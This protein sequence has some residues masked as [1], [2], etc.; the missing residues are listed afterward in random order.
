MIDPAQLREVFDRAV[1]VP[2]AD[3]ASFL[4]RAC[5]RDVALRQEVE[6]LLGADSRLGEIFDTAFP[7]AEGSAPP[8]LARTMRLAPGMRLGPYSVVEAIG[9][10]GMGEVYKAHDTRLNR[11]V[12]L[13]VLPRSLTDDAA[14]KQRFEREA[15]AVAALSHPHICPLFDVGHQNGLDF[16]VMEYLDGETL[17]AR[18]ARGKL[19]FDEA[20]TFALHIADALVAAHA[21]GIVH[22]DLKPGNVMLTAGG[23]KLLDFGLANERQPLFVADDRPRRQ[24]PITQPGTILGTLQYM[25]PEQL[26]GGL[27]DERTDIFTF[28]AVLY[29]M[30]TARRPFEGANDA[31]LIRNILQVVPPPV[32]S[33]DPETPWQ[34]SPLVDRCLAKNPVDRYQSVAEIRQDLLKVSLDG[35]P[36]SRPFG[37]S[38]V[39]RFAGVL[40]AFSTITCVV[41]LAGYV[42][43]RH[44]GATD[45]QL[46]AHFLGR[47]L[48]PQIMFDDRL[49]A[50][51]FLGA[52]RSFEDVISAAC[53]YDRRNRLFAEFE[54]SG[55]PQCAP[56]A[57]PD[58]VVVSRERLEVVTGVT[59]EGQRIGTVL[60][61]GNHGAQTRALEAGTA[62]AALVAVS[63]VSVAFIG[64]VRT[65]RRKPRSGS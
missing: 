4:A 24:E 5:G 15:R 10:G 50:L 40:G 44:A 23:A 21:A 42:H 20:I 38:R 11:S 17:A 53:V 34:I 28:G 45:L 47:A 35:R 26:A 3:R 31:S 56:V 12:A 32:S 18:L 16:L 9:A 52:L 33:I 22:R 46:Q 57:G 43:Q 7:P 59:L 61:K 2:V 6:R 62:L 49:G 63:S 29:E 13:K 25:A 48:T 1:T 39:T 36:S 14:A 51:E 41:V 58:R 65:R 60:L 30:F 37:G 27:V 54:R 64:F 19:L 55:R 8:S